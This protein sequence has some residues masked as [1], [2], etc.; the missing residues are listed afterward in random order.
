MT[1]TM[2]TGAETIRIDR[3]YMPLLLQLQQSGAAGVN[4]DTTSA[5][6][7]LEAGELVDDGELHPM[8]AAMMELIAAPALVVSVERMRLGAVAAA[9]IWATPGRAVIG[10]RVDKDLFELKLAAAALLPF[11]IFQLVH[12]R[13]LPLGPAFTYVLPA[14]VMYAAEAHI[15]GGDTAA[16]VAAM[17]AAGIGDSAAVAEL[18]ATRVAS[19]RIHSMWTGPDG[20]QTAE[21]AGMDCGP[22][23]HVLVTVD[24]DPSLTLRAAPFNEVLAAIRGTLPGS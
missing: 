20:S 4:P 12:L 21:T 1:A 18:L 23:G 3:D 22:M 8:A 14:E 24:E 9:T 17:D 13:P 6:E 19:W 7:A 11:H 16:A 15:H 10:S 5:L 2:N